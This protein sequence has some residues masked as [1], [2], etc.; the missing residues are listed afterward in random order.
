MQPKPG[1]GAGINFRAR[2]FM[3]QNWKFY[4]IHFKI[5]LKVRIGRGKSAQN[6]SGRVPVCKGSLGRDTLTVFTVV[7]YRVWVGC[8]ATVSSLEGS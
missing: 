8:E 2:Q 7:I 5:G 6:K 4:E 3:K 1:F